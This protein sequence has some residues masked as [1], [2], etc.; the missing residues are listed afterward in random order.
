MKEWLYSLSKRDQMALAICSVFCLLCFVIFFVISPL[1][2][3]FSTLQKDVQYKR[4]LASW[5]EMADSQISKTAPNK[6]Q[7]E[8]LPL[9]EA[10]SKTI[11]NS[12]LHEFHHEIQQD[13]NSQKAKVQF[14]TLPFPFLVSWLSLLAEKYQV[15]VDSIELSPVEPGVVKANITLEKKT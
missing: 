4:T 1:L 10:I 2:D 6:G 14:K 11:K 3:H 8:S 15:S 12:E 13:V 9:L 7:N 5:M